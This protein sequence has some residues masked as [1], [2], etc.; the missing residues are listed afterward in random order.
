MLRDWDPHPVLTWD[1]AT[2]G[3]SP[4]ASSGYRFGASVRRSPEPESGHCE[5]SAP[6]LTAHMASPSHVGS[7]PLR[8]CRRP[9]EATCC[10]RPSA[11]GLR[12]VTKLC[13]IAKWPSRIGRSGTGGD[14]S[15]VSLS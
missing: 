13:P 4:V 7:H 5:F 3:G 8:L 14:S 9:P 11:P 12:N 1:G 2:L 10:I 6:L 15:S